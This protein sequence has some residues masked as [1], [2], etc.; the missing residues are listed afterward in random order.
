MMENK[1][2]VMVRF[3]IVGLLTEV[4]IKSFTLLRI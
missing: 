4:L 2:K 1:L 3:Y